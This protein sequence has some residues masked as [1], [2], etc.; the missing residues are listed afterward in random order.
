MSI[1]EHIHANIRA[2]PKSKKPALIKDW[3][4]IIAYWEESV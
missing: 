3:E 2:Y 4:N 1:F